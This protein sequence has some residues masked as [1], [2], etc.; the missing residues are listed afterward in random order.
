MGKSQSYNKAQICID[1]S[2]ERKELLI[3]INI[4]LNQVSQISQLT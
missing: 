4:Y 1:L 3:I 2:Q